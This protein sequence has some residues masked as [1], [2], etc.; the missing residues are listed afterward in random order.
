MAE[1]SGD[2]FDQIAELTRAS[3][4]TIL[5]EMLKDTWPGQHSA[6]CA[7]AFTAVVVAW[8]CMFA[9]EAR[10]KVEAMLCAQVKSVLDQMESD[11]AVKQ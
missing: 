7:G 2:A 3:T 4:Y 8:A 11:R 9:P 5:V 10:P 6:I 1:D